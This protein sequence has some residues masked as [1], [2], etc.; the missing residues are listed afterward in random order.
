MDSM[1]VAGRSALFRM[2]MRQQFLGVIRPI[3][4][5]HPVY[6]YTS[7][8]RS[9]RQRSNSIYRYQI[10]W[11]DGFLTETEK[12]SLLTDKFVPTIFE[13]RVIGQT[14]FHHINAVTFARSDLWQS[15]TCWTTWHFGQCHHALVLWRNLQWSEK[16]NIWSVVWGYKYSRNIGF[17]RHN[18]SVF[19]WWWTLL[20]SNFE[21]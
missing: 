8:Q 5:G 12:S 19:N 11:L 15:L 14:A 9:P 16:Y 6:L 13:F 17:Q 10:L 4:R 18:P 2:V 7:E 1:S 21:K 3:S 20:P